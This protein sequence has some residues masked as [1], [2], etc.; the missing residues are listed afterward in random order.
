M[1]RHTVQKNRTEETTMNR[2]AEAGLRQT[3]AR[4]QTPLDICDDGT[5]QTAAV[6]SD[7]AWNHFLGRIR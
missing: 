6:Q 4:T 5:S 2:T 7:G 3:K 1:M